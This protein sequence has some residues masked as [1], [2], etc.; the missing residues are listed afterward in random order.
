MNQKGSKKGAKR[1]PK[2]LKKVSK[3]N[4]KG[5][6]KEPKRSKKGTKRWQKKQQ[7]GAQKG[8]KRSQKG[9]KKSAKRV[10]KGTKRSPK[11]DQK[12]TEKGPKRARKVIKRGPKGAQKVA[13][14]GDN[15]IYMLWTKERIQRNTTMEPKG[16]QH[17]HKGTDTTAML[18]YVHSLH[19]FFAST[20]A[21]I[22]LCC[23]LPDFRLVQ[24][25]H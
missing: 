24:A 13:K 19:I 2:G 5:S 10:P 15:I 22:H 3:S 14:R 21:I 16:A 20:C 12:E 23:I 18:S 17:G 6:K 8:P 9:A 1:T 4:Q 11:G 25:P 7:K